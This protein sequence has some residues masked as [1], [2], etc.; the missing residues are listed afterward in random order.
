MTCDV[1]N[2]ARSRARAKQQLSGK[3]R[4]ACA[5]G[6]LPCRACVRTA[7]QGPLRSASR[8]CEGKAAFVRL[9]GGLRGVSAPEGAVSEKDTVTPS[10]LALNT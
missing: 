1:A 8:L 3:A 7:L 6:C 4:A 2:S 10:L 9:G 5:S